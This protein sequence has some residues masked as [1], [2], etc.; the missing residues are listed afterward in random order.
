MV[1][2][3]GKRVGEGVWRL[4][5]VSRPLFPLGA[6]RHLHGR[7][8]GT[9]LPCSPRLGAPQPRP[10]SRGSFHTR[11]PHAPSRYACIQ[12]LYTSHSSTLLSRE[13]RPIPPPAVPP[14]L[15]APPVP[16]PGTPP[17]PSPPS[18]PPLPPSAPPL[19]SPSPA[20]PPPQPPAPPRPPFSPSPLPAPPPLPPFPEHTYKYAGGQCGG[21]PRSR[22]PSFST[23]SSS[24]KAVAPDDPPHSR[25]GLPL[26]PPLGFPF[27]SVSMAERIRSPT[28]RPSRHLS[29]GLLKR[30]SLPATVPPSTPQSVPS[31]LLHPLPPH[32]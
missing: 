14:S 7:N 15:P 12:M 29:Q 3:R 31:A 23:G 2:E 6:A 32:P 21:Q 16:P 4:P 20:P 8:F 30:E 26:F 9:P 11:S 18:P 22:W 17:P 10:E 13:C 5:N 28:S 1:G 19:A 27:S 24:A 25:R